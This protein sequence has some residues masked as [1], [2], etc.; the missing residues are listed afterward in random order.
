M[1]SFKQFL[2]ESSGLDRLN[3]FRKEPDYNEGHLKTKKLFQG[4]TYPEDIE[5]VTK[6]HLHDAMHSKIIKKIPVNTL[7]A[8]QKSVKDDYVEDIMKKNEQ[9][10]GNKVVLNHRG[11]NYLLDGTHHTAASILSGHSHIDA[12]YHETGE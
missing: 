10:K 6:D 1:K 12:K 9:H 5:G 2:N 8:V 11:K 7:H 4:A 3:Q